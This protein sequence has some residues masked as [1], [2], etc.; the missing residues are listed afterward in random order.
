MTKHGLLIVNNTRS[1]MSMG[2][3]TKLV[4][5]VMHDSAKV[6]TITYS[7]NFPKEFVLGEE[8]KGWNWPLTSGWSFNRMFQNIVYKKK[9]L[10]MT[11]NTL[12]H[13]VNPSVYP[14]RRDATNIVTIPDLIPF[15][16]E[17]RDNSPTWF[18]RHYVNI[19][20]HF[21]NIL[22][23]TNYVKKDLINAGFDGRINAIP[24]PADLTF[25]PIKDKVELRKKLGLPLN[26][27]LIL[28]V[29][30]NIKRKNLGLVKD[31]IS[32]LGEQ[33]HLVRVVTGIGDSINFESVNDELLNQIYNACD[34]LFFPSLEEGFGIPIVEALTVGLPVVASNIEVME[35]IAGDAAKLVEPDTSLSIRGIRE[36]ID[37]RDEFA[38]K[39][40]R[41]AE[42]YSFEKFNQRMQA[43]YGKIQ[44]DLGYSGV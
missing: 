23:Y 9:F 10:A 33:Y 34:V 3:Y 20:K 1:T 31:V 21:E 36:V 42:K 35:E 43:Y 6:V 40:F 13:Y 7:K 26:K 2:R 14:F 19:Y 32:G 18:D 15:K 5:Q 39:G 8:I 28:S 4:Q 25:R 24:L 17:F 27:K 11:E 30:L 38:Q 29:S 44:A 22:C 12:I 41:R 37:N 16:P